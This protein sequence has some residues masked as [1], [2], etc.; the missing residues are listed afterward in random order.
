MLLILF[1]KTSYLW[2]IAWALQ[3]IGYYFV[4]KKVDEDPSYAMI[5][6]FAE[7][8]LTK[9]LYPYQLSFFRPFFVALVL[10]IAGLYLNPFHGLG[11]LY[12]LIGAIIYLGFLFRL[13]NRLRKAFGKSILYCIVYVLFPPAFLLLMGLFNSHSFTQPTFPE[14][15]YPKFVRYLMRGAIG[16]LGTAEVVAVAAVAGMFAIRSLPPRFMVRELF[17]EVDTYVEKIENTGSVLSREEILGDKASIISSAPTSREHFF[18]S[19]END[20]NV[21]VL[22]YIIGSNLENSNGMASINI[23]QMK[24]STAQGE[25]LT[26]VIQAGGSSRWF[27]N[28]ITE[29]AIGRY[30][31]KN[32]K[33]ETATLLNSNV[34]MSEKE[35]L[36]DFL[37]WAKENYPADRY[38][39]V[40]WDHGGGFGLGYG[41]DDLNAKQA[42][43]PTMLMSEL[44]EA[45]KNSG[46]KFDVIGF[47]ACLMQ[48]IECALALE[49]Y[50]DYYIASEETESGLGWF[51][52]DAFGKLAQDPT[53]P[54]PEFAKDL[55]ATF[56]SLNTTVNDGE[57]DTKST[58]SVVDLTMVKPIYEQLTNL[59]TVS[60]ESIIKDPEYYADISSSALNSYTFHNDEQIDLVHYLTILDA[61]DYESQICRDNACLALADNVKASI[62]YRNKNSAEGINGLAFT[63]PIKNLNMYS[64]SYDQLKGFNMTKQMDFYNDFFSIMAAQ[65]LK[66][67]EQTGN[68]FSSLTASAITQSEWYKPGYENYDTTVESFENI[69]LKESEG[70]Y[71]VE[72]PEKVNKLIDNVQVAAYQKEG[73]EL[74][75]LGR[76]YIGFDNFEGQTVLGMDDTWVHVDNNLISYTAEQSRTTDEGII[77]TGS[78]KAILNGDQPVTLHIEWSPI[79]EGEEKPAQGRIIGYSKAD[80]QFAFMEKGNEELKA[81]D[82]LDFLFEY[83][84]KDGNVL[85]EEKYGRTLYVTNP[86]RITVQDKQM[87]DCDIV[88]FGILTDVYQRQLTTEKVEYHV[89]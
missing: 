34:C 22:E 84:D 39:L 74:R 48:T 50:A 57:V 89:N 78:T 54:T 27:T 21:V 68:A 63:F 3:S 30:T 45:L 15:N 25:N 37:K 85:K 32:G 52:T 5:P 4:L 88:F 26:Y 81:G 64:Y 51:Y 42:D 33:I 19:H 14:E 43:V 60:R 70:G 40:F 82:R 58:L 11:R 31:I 16:L 73:E 35:S 77:Y 87:Q 18:P 59:F 56:D 79:P 75:Y 7:W 66:A 9:K 61:V 36:E 6:F 24:N 28:E 8:R 69:P 86:D 62:P 1:L 10:V 38:M 47:D 29:D 49:P 80:N 71:V 17:Q 44:T 12:I 65:Q 67:N 55:I 2:V 20:K 83:H 53:I 76:D 13:Y 41:Q 46:M 72:L 23:K